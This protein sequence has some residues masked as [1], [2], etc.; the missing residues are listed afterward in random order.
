MVRKGLFVIQVTRHHTKLTKAS[1]PHICQ[2][3]LHSWS[4][5]IKAFHS[6][7]VIKLCNM[8]FSEN[9][10]WLAKDIAT[11]SP[12]LRCLHK[13]QTKQTKPLS[14]TRARENHEIQGCQKNI[15]LQSRSQWRFQIISLKLQPPTGFWSSSWHAVMRRTDSTAAGAIG[16]SMRESKSS[17]FC[18]LNLVDLAVWLLRGCFNSRIIAFKRWIYP[19]TPNICHKWSLFFKQHGFKTL[20][21]KIIL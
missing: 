5:N 1:L 4:A 3:F 6:Q 13:R 15:Y 19:E 10:Y 8:D 21:Y 17:P 2:L 20:V 7:C 9:G 16:T 18:W 12:T 14:S 11:F